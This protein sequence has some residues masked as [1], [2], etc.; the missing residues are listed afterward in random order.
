MKLNKIIKKIALSSLIVVMGTLSMAAFVPWS[1]LGGGEENL[2]IQSVRDRRGSGGG[3]HHGRRHRALQFLDLNEE[4]EALIQEIHST[5]QADREALHS[6][7]KLS[8]QLLHEAVFAEVPDETAINDAAINLGLTI[9]DQVVLRRIIMN[10]IKAVLTPEQ[11][12]RWEEMKSH[13]RGMREDGEETGVEEG[14]SS[15]V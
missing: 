3:F 11:I 13:R 15:P 10:E 2:S 9:G 8:R 6:D 5:H 1:L 12:E 14:D 7:M 4:Q